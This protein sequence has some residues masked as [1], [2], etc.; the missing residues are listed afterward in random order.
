MADRS[1][2][3]TSATSLSALRYAVC[4]E[5]AIGHKIPLLMIQVE[6]A[7]MAACFLANLNS[8][9]L[10]YVARNKV[11]GN[12]MAYFIIKQLP[13]FSSSFY[14]SED[15]KFI[16]DRVVE[17]TYTGS[18]M[19]EFAKDAGYEGPPFC[20]DD[21]RRAHLRGQIDA[22][23]AH[24]YGLTRDE[25][26]YILDPHAAMGA[27]FPGETF[28]GLKANEQAEFGEYRTEQIVLAAFDELARSERF[29]SDVA[30]RES[31]IEV[32]SRTSALLGPSQVN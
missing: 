11:G 17:L 29:G 25:L 13:V 18:D 15:I 7:N 27:D 21:A 30:E 5:V 14:T 6:A 19:H 26:H 4:F 28:R 8:I 2:D 20:W 12:S 22:Y 24:L 32:P 10:D 23:Y 9:V 1:E 31:A 16:T 3:V